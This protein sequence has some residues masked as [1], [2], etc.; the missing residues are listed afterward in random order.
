M[1]LLRELKHHLRMQTTGPTTVAVPQGK[2]F[3]YFE[4]VRTKIAEATED[5]LFVDPYLDADFVSR[6]LPGVRVGATIRLLTTDKKLK[7]LIPAVDMFVKQ[8]GGSI[9]VRNS[10]DLHD[11]FL[12]IDRTSGYQSGAS[13]KDGA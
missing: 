2:V 7:T 12:F 10:K 9:E 1:V 8:N 6:Y 4:E 11:R 3:E 5:V 13:F